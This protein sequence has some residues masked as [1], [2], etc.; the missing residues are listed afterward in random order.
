MIY[1]CSSN[2]DYEQ[3]CDERDSDEKDVLNDELEMGE[4]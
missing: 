4:A 2:E 3:E 1:V